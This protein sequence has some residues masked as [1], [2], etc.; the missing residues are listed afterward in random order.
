MTSNP[1]AARRAEPFK[2]NRQFD[3][4]QFA[5][6]ANAR[7]VDH[8]RADELEWYVTPMGDVNLRTSDGWY[9]K[10]AKEQKRLIEEERRLFNY[11]RAHP[12]D[13]ITYEH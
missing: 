1:L 10:Y 13:Q 3:A 5:A 2:P 9:A 4:E 12:V 8:P 7:F 6:D 11:R